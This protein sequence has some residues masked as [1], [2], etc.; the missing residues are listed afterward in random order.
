[1][2][3]RIERI[4][5]TELMDSKGRLIPTVKVVLVSEH[6]EAAQKQKTRES[7]RINC[8]RQSRKIPISQWLSLPEPA[9]GCGRTASQQIEGRAR[10]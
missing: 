8:S 2:T 5:T 4:T 1:M 10:T 9:D 7:R 6:E 3:F